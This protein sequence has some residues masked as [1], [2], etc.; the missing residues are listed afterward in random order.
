[1][2]VTSDS[3]LFITL[4]SCRYDVFIDAYRPNMIR[5]GLI[6][7]KAISPSFFTLPSH[8]A[9]F[10]GFTPA[11]PDK[12]KWL[13]PK[14]GKLWR[15][16]TTNISPNKRDY[17]RV[18]GMDL[19]E[20]MNNAGYTTIG[21]GGVRWFDPSVPTGKILTQNFKKYKFFGNYMHA[22]DQV[23][24]VYEEALKHKKVWSFIN[25]GETHDPYRYKGCDFPEKAAYKK[26]FKNKM[27]VRATVYNQQMDCV[28][29][30]DGVMAPL[31]DLFMDSGASVVITADHGELFGEDN[32]WQHQDHHEMTVT[33]PLI[34][35]IKGKH[36]V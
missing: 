14:H 27:E 16:N 6:A 13:N 2:K 31:L 18:Q 8:M 28:S 30:L 36:I 24:F 10:E 15:V 34:M 35:N 4:D 17:M 26:K 25:F 19:I 5:R 9:F 22:E 33:V 32:L 11:V 29:Y 3:F 21:T 23:D 20:G 7:H 12:G 1:M